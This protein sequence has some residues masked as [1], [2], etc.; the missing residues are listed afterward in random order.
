VAEWKLPGPDHHTLGKKA[1][2]DF[3][4]LKDGRALDRLVKAGQF[5]RGRSRGKQVFWSGADVAAYLQLEGRF[6]VGPLSADEKEPDDE[7]S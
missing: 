5:P 7:D 3:L 2:A 1:V 4:G 6:I